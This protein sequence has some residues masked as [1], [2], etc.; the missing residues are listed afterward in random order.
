MALTLRPVGCKHRRRVRL[1]KTSFKWG[2]GG[3]GVCLSL[4]G[5]AGHDGQSSSSPTVRVRSPGMAEQR[6]K[7]FDPNHK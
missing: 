1:W 2:W 5:R 6:G 3:V 4:L 7:E